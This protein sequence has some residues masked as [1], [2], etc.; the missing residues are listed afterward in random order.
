MRNRPFLTVFSI[1]A[2]VAVV[3]LCGRPR[4]SRPN[5]PNQTATVEVLN[6]TLEPLARHFNDRAARV[7][8]V[9]LLSP[10]CSECVLGAE[11]IKEELVDRFAAERLD[12]TIVWAPMLESDN[13][14][15]AKESAHLFDNTHVRQFY[16]PDVLA[17]KSYRREVFPDAYRKGAASLPE[18]HWLRERLPADDYDPGPEWDIYMFFDKRVAWQDV[19]PRP[20]RYVRHLGRIVEHGDEYLSLMWVDDYSNPPVEGHLSEQI[21]RLGDSMV[22]R[23]R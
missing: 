18:D 8:F 1:A 7:R 22:K 15:A 19:P 12:V 20:T 14:A 13:E 6:N 10:T 23:S 3:L 21:R 4:A 9:A 2:V 16:D 11:A 5:G 17:G